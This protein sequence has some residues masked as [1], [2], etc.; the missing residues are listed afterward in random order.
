MP[1]LQATAPM[2]W[3]PIEVSVSSPRTV[4]VTG[5]KGWYSANWRS[6]AGR[7]AMGTNPLLRK[8]SRVRNM[9]VLLAVSTLLAARP[10]AADSQ[11][12]A[13]ANSTRIPMAASHSKGSAVGRNPMARATPITSA[14]TATVC[15]RLPITWPVSTAALGTAI[16]VAMDM[17]EG[18]I[19]RFRTM[20]IARAAV[21]TG[22]VIGSL[23]QTVA[24]LALVIGVALAI[25]FRPTANPLEWLAAI[26]I[27]V[28]FAFALIWLSA[29]L[30]LAA[31]SVETAS[32]TPMFLTLLPFLSSGFVP[33]D[34]MPVGLRQFAE[35]EPFT[36]VTQTVRGLL[37]D[38][39]IGTHAIVA[40][41]WSAGIA[42]ASY[43]WAV[44]LYNRRRAAGSN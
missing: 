13:N 1:T 40:V 4:W 30:G 43:L 11:M 21:L 25:G 12:S 44:R 16:S 31:K 22:H 7:V 33:T 34:T 5:V 20:A 2:A 27:L 41:A 39:P 17:T 28:L 35:Y 29:A 32:N 9:G 10:R 3:V 42:I 15:S 26:G 6:P 36:P 37:T 38:N 18:I 8:G 23:L 14:R 24:V 19:D